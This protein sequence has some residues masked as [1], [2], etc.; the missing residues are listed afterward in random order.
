MSNNRR[1]FLRQLGT[2][3]GAGLLATTPIASFAEKLV[4]QENMK[5][6]SDKPTTVS[7]LQTTDVHCQIHPHDE[8]FW[9]NNKA[10]FRKT[11]GYAYLPCE[12]D[13]VPPYQVV[14]HIRFA[15]PQRDSA[16][17][18]DQ[19]AAHMLAD[20][21]AMAPTNAEHFGSKLTAADLTAVVEPERSVSG[22]ATI[23]LY[24]PCRV[25]DDHSN[26]DPAWID[27]AF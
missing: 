2:A 8:L 14:L 12:S 19:V 20:G 21:W 27:I 22:S 17:Y 18:L 25:T 24:G 16:R 7:I 15:V 9:E 3:T 10:V 4:E 5:D 26:D 13:G 11:G 6:Y 23:R 1:D